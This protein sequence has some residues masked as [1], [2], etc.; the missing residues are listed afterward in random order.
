M[1]LLNHPIDMIAIFETGGKIVPSNIWSGKNN[2]A[3]P[4]KTGRKRKN[5]FCMHEQWQGSL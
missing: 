3:V 4:G 2:Q 1:K 5:R